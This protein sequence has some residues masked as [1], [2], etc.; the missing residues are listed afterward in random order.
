MNKIDPPA[1]T[2]LKNQARFIKLDNPTFTHSQALEVAAKAAGFNSY[3]HARSA[4]FPRK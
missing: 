3:A 1:I 2:H 4:L